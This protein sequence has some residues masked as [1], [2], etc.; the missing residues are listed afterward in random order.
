[1]LVT[2]YKGN[3]IN[4]KSSTLTQSLS[5]NVKSY[6]AYILYI[7]NISRKYYLHNVYKIRSCKNRSWKETTMMIRVNLY[8]ILNSVKSG[9]SYVIDTDNIQRELRKRTISV[10]RNAELLLYNLLRTTP[11]YLY[12]KII[13]HSR[14]SCLVGTY[15]F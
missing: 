5:I 12:N 7:T 14:M 1:M 4:I 9:S 3:L 13:T 10:I 8:H 15:T 6:T 11:E 2:I